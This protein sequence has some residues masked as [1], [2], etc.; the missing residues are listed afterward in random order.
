MPAANREQE[1]GY[2]LI[3]NGRREFEK[4]IGFRVPTSNWLIRAGTRAG[5]LGYVAGIA[6]ILAIILALPLFALAEFGVGGWFARSL[7]LSWAAS[8]IGPGGCDY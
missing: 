8:R 2:Y 4:E 3:A 6:V 5:I 7:R 1:P